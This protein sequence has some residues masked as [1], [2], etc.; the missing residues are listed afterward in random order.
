MSSQ[1]K[2]R[3]IIFSSTMVRAIL[4]ER[5]FQTR[6]VIKPQPLPHANDVTLDRLSCGTARFAGRIGNAVPDQLIYCPHG[7]IGDRLWVRETWSTVGLFDDAKPSDL[8]PRGVG[9]IRYHADGKQSGKLRPSIF[10][11]R[12]ASRITLEIE[13]IRV[14]RLNDISNEDAAAE[15]AHGA[16]LSKA[17]LMDEAARFE[18]RVFQS[19]SPVVTRRAEFAALWESINGKGSW[20]AN[21]YVWCISFRRVQDAE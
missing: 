9:S 7:M 15:G 18:R 16:V 6:R 5:K 13:D 21:P 10:M 1:N 20:E 17:R 14:E 12:W 8:D 19:S 11:P 2:E 3:P 4:E